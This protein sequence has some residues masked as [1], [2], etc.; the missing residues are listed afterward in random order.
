MG[1]LTVLHTDFLITAHD[2]SS[3]SNSYPGVSKTRASLRLT[4]GLFTRANFW[5][6]LVSPADII[7]YLLSILPKF[8]EISCLLLASLPLSSSVWFT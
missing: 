6:S 7:P 2:F 1:V 5:F 3:T 8:V 4:P